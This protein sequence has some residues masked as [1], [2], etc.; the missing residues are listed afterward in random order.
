MCK[1]TAMYLSCGPEAQVVGG[2]HCQLGVRNAALLGVAG[3]GRLG[4]K[5]GESGCARQ[6]RCAAALEGGRLQELG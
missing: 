5:P 6:P 1:N 4:S 2:V 3:A